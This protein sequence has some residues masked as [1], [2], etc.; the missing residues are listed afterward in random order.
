[1]ASLLTPLL[2]CSALAPQR[3][4][5]CLAAAAS[6]H[7]ASHGGCV[8][9]TREHGKNGP[10]TDRLQALGIEARAPASLARIPSSRARAGAHSARRCPSSSTAPGLTAPGWRRR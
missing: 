4:R 2:P 3:R 8:L 10:L 6:A 9:V 5:P 1:M 7:A